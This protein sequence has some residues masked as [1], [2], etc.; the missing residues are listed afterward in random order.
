MLLC[1]TPKTKQNKYNQTQLHS[2]T[3]TVKVCEWHQVV[4]R[5]A[6]AA[7]AVVGVDTDVIAATVVNLA[8]VVEYDGTCRKTKWW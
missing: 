3:E 1:A 6:E 2:L 5:A 8:F 7:V 4:A